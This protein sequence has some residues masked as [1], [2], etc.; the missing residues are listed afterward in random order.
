M[1]QQDLPLNK[2]G[3]AQARYAESLLRQEYDI[4]TICHSPL[5]RAKQTAEIIKG[6]RN[7]T[8]VSLPNL[9][10]MNLGIMEGE[11][12]GDKKW[13]EA[14]ENGQLI[15]GAETQEDFFNRALEGVNQAL[16]YPAP[17]LIVSHGG[18][19]RQIKKILKMGPRD[20]PNC[21]PLLFKATQNLNFP[22]M[23][24]SLNP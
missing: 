4:Q 16:K 18:V 13:L 2:A 11:L 15:E 24:C 23:V 8:M 5:M 14:W 9:K 6:D 3:I 10:E 19:Y 7:L 12:L 20:L 17:V 1:G 22:W 21:S